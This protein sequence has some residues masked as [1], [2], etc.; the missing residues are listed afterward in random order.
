MSIPA[1]FARLVKARAG[2]CCEY[3]QI[4]DEDLDSPFQIDHIIPTCHGG[5]TAIENLAYACW[6]CNSF[7]GPN[8]TG[9]DPETNRVVRLFHP[10][11]D[12]WNAH[13]RWE[14]VTL[15]GLTTTGRVTIRLLRINRA[16]AV[17][18]REKRRS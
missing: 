11:K 9:I 14:G 17:D 16:D 6:A 5:L 15:L 8:L 1:S 13:F 4:F 10:R 18:H 2:R 12:R 3:C 7:K